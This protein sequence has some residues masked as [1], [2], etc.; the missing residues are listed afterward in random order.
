M[1]IDEFSFESL[2][3]LTGSLDCHYVFYC[4]FWF[5]FLAEYL[6]NEPRVHNV[7]TNK[8]SYPFDFIFTVMTHDSSFLLFTLT[9]A[10]FLM[11]S[12]IVSD[13]DKSE[14]NRY[15]SQNVDKLNFR[16]KNFHLHD[17]SRRHIAIHLINLIYGY[18]RFLYMLMALLVMIKLYFLCYD[19]SKCNRVGKM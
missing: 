19:G 3:L 13:K 5:P 4:F 16:L 9:F 7:E 15:A 11:V 12:W 2:G 10:L 18:F 17:T 14:S 8:V 1:F 6:Q